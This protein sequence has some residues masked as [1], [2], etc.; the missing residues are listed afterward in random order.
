MNLHWN[1]SHKDW[2]NEREKIK[3]G[4]QE[5]KNWSGTIGAGKSEWKNGTAELEW[6]NGVGKLGM[7]Q[8]QWETGK[9]DSIFFHKFT[10]YYP[11]LRLM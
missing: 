1:P 7:E 8:S 11:N 9:L 5:W 4:K 2:E 10:I 3:A 6:K